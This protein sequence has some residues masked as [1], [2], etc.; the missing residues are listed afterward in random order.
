[1]EERK[2]FAQLLAA[3]VRSG[4]VWVIATMRSDFWHRAAE[5][6]EL[7]QLADGHGRLDL[8]PPTPAELS[9]MIRGPAEAA[10]IHFEPHPSSGIPLNDLIAQE[11]SGEP[12]ALPL[13]SYLLDQLYRRDVEEAGGST[14]THASY[15]ALGGLKG[16][17]ATRA[18][19]VVSAQ[20]PEVREALRHVLFA[21]V[22]M[23]VAEG[24]VE[25]AVARRAP[26]TEFPEGT[27]R[28]RL[29]E[30]LLDPAARLV[31]AD[32]AEGKAASVRLAHEALLSEWQTAR[33][34]VMGNAEAL[35]S[36][37]TL[38]ERYARWQSI[39]GQQAD[40]A[41]GR[42]MGSL[43]SRFVHERG[44]LA[45]V[46]LTDARRLLRDY[47]EELSPQLIAYIDR[48][49][50]QIRRTVRL[51]QAA[52]A[53]IALLAVAASIA[54][55]IARSK[56]REAQY[57][58]AEARKAQRQVLTD[59]AAERLKDGDLTLAR[60]MMLEVFKQRASGEAPDP[61]ASNVL[62]EIAA[63]DPAVAILTG[64]SAP[65]RWVSYSPDGS[66]LLT[67]SL[68]HTVRV[69]DA[70][71]GLELLRVPEVYAGGFSPDGTR[72]L[73][74]AKGGV[75][76]ILDA[77]TGTP[78]LLIRGPEDV[79]SI[80]YS[81]DG[82]RIVT[83][84]S[85]GVW[86]WDARTGA[87][88]AEFVHPAEEEY[89]RASFSPDG[90]RVAVATGKTMRVWDARTGREL[91]VLAGHRDSVIT[92]AYSLDGTRIVSGGT[93]GT[94]RV[95]DALTG[96]EL[97]HVEHGGQTWDAMFSPDGRTFATAAAD[98]TIR[99]WD[100]ATGRQLR[101]L[102][103]HVQIVAGVAFS[104]DGT[105]LA[106]AAWDRTARVWDL[107]E[108]PDALVLKGHGD[109]VGSVSYSPD[110]ARLLTASADG[111]ARIWDVHTGAP[112]AVLRGHGK[113][114]GVAVYSPDGARV[115]TGSDDKSLRVW[116]ARTGATLLSLATPEGVTSAAYSPDGR[117]IVASYADGTFDTRDA[118]SGTPTSDFIKV[119]RDYI[120]STVYSPDGARILTGS[121]DKTV[122]V[123]D[124]RTLKHLL[125]IPNTDFVQDALYSPDGQLILSVGNDRLAYLWN[126]GT[127]EELRVLAGHHRPMTSAGFSRD[128][129]RI[130]TGS[131]DRTVRIWDVPTGTQ[132]AV[133]IGHRDVVAGVCFSPDGLHVA[134]AS[135]DNTARIWDA[136]IADD[137]PAQVFFQQ[138]VETDPLTDVRLTNLGSPSTTT[139]LVKDTLSAGIAKKAAPE[140][141]RAARCARQAGAYYDP[142]RLG[143]GID[144]SAIDP[145]QALGACLPPGVSQERSAQ[146]SYN[147]ARA[148][149]ARGDFAGARRRLDSALADGYRAARID[150]ALLLT[151]PAAKML[152]TKRAA[153]LLE[154]S[155]NSGVDQAGFELGALYEHG[156][157]GPANGPAAW[158][159]DTAQAWRWY[160]KAAGHS[161]PHA[162][163]RLAE[164]AEREVITGSKPDAD[165]LSAFT[166]YARAAERARSL[167]WPDS[168]WRSWR[169]RRAT[170][171]HVLARAGLTQQ[172]AD[173][174]QTVLNVPGPE[175][176]SR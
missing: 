67:V 158:P 125:L 132:L 35:K 14:L 72:I 118:A 136:R 146:L 134:S 133:L 5:T 40:I 122:R 175:R 113:S 61:A 171:A 41:S 23:S 56:E 51:K 2:R 66:R 126:A 82:A 139:L 153:S 75:V 164:R 81:A 97:L 88:L 85:K 49:E 62:L 12:G 52:V 42:G 1:S 20:P 3:L 71:T 176:V 86:L 92:F 123:W 112:V 116:D 36:R 109:V 163:A 142:D 27:A 108:G 76:R 151:N 69:W 101:V 38:E 6:P 156:V 90:S 173:A 120:T 10:A 57:Q 89:Y 162:L 26:M 169:Y 64:H 22:Q 172:V 73:T 100:A 80:A 46:D 140:T 79:N 99:L 34:Y 96:K 147:S 74:A 170:L 154:E 138:T 102:T 19:A 91:L 59:A 94:A 70:R 33:D 141:S 53:A 155:W 114:V 8:L 137:G 21:L 93:D 54:A 129:G 44:L 15:N 145:E 17:I 7:V 45:D 16:A 124:A 143:P 157:A 150:L 131:F 84:F 165:L 168:V 11:A 161:E 128:G 130:V 32:A 29:I 166:L 58:T 98:K 174:Y 39:V 18:D 119:H 37:R 107:R 24:S 50:R 83:A 148:L 95:W 30:T 68:D 31:V 47:R 104:P 25:R 13:L 111:T 144:Q 160:E 115:L 117:H 106:S 9:Q 110:G 127:G 43:R 48:S 60:G 159:A 152:D 65:V 167:G 135:A 105:H 63:S 121:V 77:H 87:R 55:W 149:L 103:G 28:R 78:F 4:L